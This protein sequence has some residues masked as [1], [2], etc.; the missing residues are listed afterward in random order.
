MSSDDAT[1]YIF[2]NGASFIGRICKFTSIYSN[3]EWFS[4]SGVMGAS[5]ALN[6]QNEEFF[7]S[8]LYSVDFMKVIYQRIE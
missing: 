5:S 7:I 6:I 2:T 4:T 3:L 8:S 1:L